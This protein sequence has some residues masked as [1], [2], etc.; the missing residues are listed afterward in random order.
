MKKSR[1][2]LFFPAYVFLG[3]V[4]LG[5]VINQV[6]NERVYGDF[7]KYLVA[8]E[9]SYKKKLAESKKNAKREERLLRKKYKFIGYSHLRKIYNP[10]SGCNINKV[11]YIGRD[12]IYLITLFSGQEYAY[13]IDNAFY[14]GWTQSSKQFKP[15][16]EVCNN[17][18]CRGL[19]IRQKPSETS[20]QYY[21][22]RNYFKRAII[23]EVFKF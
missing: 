4:F 7:K 1:S 6:E 3:L 11:K 12:N 5:L 14:N 23:K 17:F 22:R 2:N 21:D 18:V 8:E 15:R 9:N 16:R 20:L 10:C 19:Y 13:K